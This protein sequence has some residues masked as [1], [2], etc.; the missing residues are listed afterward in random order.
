[1]PIAARTVKV[2]RSRQEK[3]KNHEND[4]DYGVISML[5][6]YRTMES[7]ST[8]DVYSCYGSR[9]VVLCLRYS[10]VVPLF[11]LLIICKVKF[12]STNL[13][14]ATENYLFLFFR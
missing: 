7:V 1:M 6:S 4:L 11:N 13:K 10:R 3:K 2:A 14:E 5:I 8:F 9:P 12:F